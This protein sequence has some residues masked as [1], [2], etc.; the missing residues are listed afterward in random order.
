MIVFGGWGSIAGMLGLVGISTVLGDRVG[1]LIGG[2]AL[3]AFGQWLHTNDV[4][5]ELDP[6]TG[7]MAVYRK[8]HH[9]FWVPM[10]WWG[11]L[12]TMAGV[13]ALFGG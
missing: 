13:A 6:G 8:K 10:R 4:H 5:E 3:I 1:P 11:V 7:Q 12:F 9:V 2:L